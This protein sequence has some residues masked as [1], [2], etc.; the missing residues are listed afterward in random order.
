MG[1][2]RTG[3]PS[4][5]ATSASQ[6]AGGSDRRLWSRRH[7]SGRRRPTVARSGDA[8][9]YRA[10]HAPADPPR[11]R[12]GARG[13]PA[14]RRPRVDDHQPRPP[15]PRQPAR[16]PRDRGQRPLRRRRPRD[17]RGRRRRALHRAR[18]RRAARGRR[19]TTPWSRSACAT[20]ARWWRGAATAP[21]RSPPPRTS[22]RW[23]ASRS[24]PPAVSAACTAAPATR[25][26]SRP[27]SPRWR[28]RP[29]AVVCAGVKSI[30]D[31]GRHARAAR[32]PQRPG[33]RLPHRPVPGLLPRRLRATASTGA[34]SRPP[35]SP[36]VMHARSALAVRRRAARGA[37]RSPRPTSSTAPCTTRCSPRASPRPTP[38]ACAARTSRRSCSSTSTRA[39]DGLS[40]AVNVALVR[41]N[42]VLA[43]GDRGGAD[44]MTGSTT[45]LRRRRRLDER[46]RRRAARAAAP[47]HRHARATSRVLGGGAAANIAAWLGHDGHPTTLRRPHRRRPARAAPAARSSSAAA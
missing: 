14:R 42:A 27:T 24:S 25:G 19:R 1:R 20:S 43:A 41:S 39:T 26:T 34:S 29:V 33:A 31:V 23:P 10:R 36:A 4:R 45:S 18:R 5:R 40:L 3:R 46:R 30:L 35:R 7:R 15:P 12:R 2:S 8:R 9:R 38:P 22:P 6:C 21:R 37:T 32:D 17:D 13:R 11:G 28:P 16:R 47:G 44:G